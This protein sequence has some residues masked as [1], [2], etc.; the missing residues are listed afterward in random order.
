[1]IKYIILP[2]KL[3]MVIRCRPIRAGHPGRH[4]LPDHRQPRLASATASRLPHGEARQ[5]HR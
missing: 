5:L 3:Q 2:S 4:T 1:M